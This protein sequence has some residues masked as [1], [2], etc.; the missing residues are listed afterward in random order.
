MIIRSK[1]SYYCSFCSNSFLYFCFNILMII[2]DNRGLVD[3]NMMSSVYLRQECQTCDHMFNHECSRCQ[4]CNKFN[5]CRIIIGNFSRIPMHIYIYIYHF[6]K[7]KNEV[8][9][10]TIYFPPQKNLLVSF[11]VKESEKDTTFCITF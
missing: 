2:E 11:F 3:S 4:T 9:F 6:W 5:G 8:D 1:F 10:S 7:K